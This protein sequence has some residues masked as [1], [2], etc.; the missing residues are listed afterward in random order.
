MVAVRV[1]PSL[2]G[3]TAEILPNAHCEHGRRFSLIRTTVPTSILGPSWFH[4]ARTWSSCK[5]SL[6][7]RFQKSWRTLLMCSQVDNRFPGT[8]V[9][10]PWGRV[11]SDLPI[12]YCAGVNTG[13]S[14]GSVG[15]VVIGRELRMLSI[16]I[17]KVLSY[18][19][20][21][22]QSPMTRLKWCLNNLTV[23]SHNP[24]KCGVASGMKCHVIWRSVANLLTMS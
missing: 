22:K 3:W 7:H 9:K 6:L 2:P 8:A 12:R 13:E 18:L 23:D 4:F 15:M 10:S 17:V 14:F 24:P 19:N 16:S 11:V 5:Y 1:V 21:N 20:V